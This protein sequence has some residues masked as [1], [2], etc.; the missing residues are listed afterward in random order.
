MTKRS[1][2]TLS[3]RLM[4]FIGIAVIAVTSLST[5]WNYQN[6]REHIREEARLRAADTVNKTLNQLIVM[7]GGVQKSTNFLA[8]VVQNFTGTEKE[9]QN[10]LKNTISTNKNIYGGTIALAIKSTE[11]EKGFAPYYFRPEGKL[12]YVDLADERY[13]YYQQDWFTKAVESMQPAWSEP[14]FDDGGGNIRMITYAVPVYR[15][16]ADNKKTIYAVVTGDVSLH[17][18]HKL[19]QTIQLGDSGYAMLFSKK[20][21]LLSH[22]N[23]SLKM[24]NFLDLVNQQDN[25]QQWMAI[26]KAMFSGKRDKRDLPCLENK[27]QHCFFA[28]GSLDI[29][30][31][32]LAVSFPEKEMF[33]ELDQYTTRFSIVSA[34]V[35]LFLLIIIGMITSR[36]TQP[37]SSLSKASY[38]IGQGDFDV[39]LPYAKQQDEVGKLVSAFKKMQAALKDYIDQLEV[40]TARTSRLEGELSAAHQ[41]QMSMLPGNGEIY[42]NHPNHQLWAKLIPAKSVG[43]DLYQFSIE[44]NNKLI[45]VVAD[46]SDKGVAAALFMARTTSL[47]KQQLHA[48][49]SA[50]QL[51]FSMNNELIEGNDACMFVTL[52]YAEL[53]LATG[54]MVYVSA[55]H[56]SPLLIRGENVIALP[57][58]GGPALGLLDDGEYPLNHAQLEAD[59]KLFIYTDGVDEAFN[60]QHEQFGLT[61]LTALLQQQKNEAIDVIGKQCFTG[62]DNFA[63]NTE[64]SDDI[65]VM[66]VHFNPSF[67]FLMDHKN[68]QHTQSYALS[69]DVKQ[70]DTVFSHL[71]EFAS[72]HQLS[73]ACLQN[74]KLIGEEI[75]V[76]AISYSGMQTIQTLYFVL[77]LDQQGLLMEFIDPGKAY[78]PLTDAPA[79]P[80]E[81]DEIQ[82]GGLG[83]HFVKSLSLE[84]KYQ[85][86][87]QCNHLCVLLPLN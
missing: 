26:K 80:D 23:K 81:D 58:E 40:E 71:N 35:I 52:F 27:N 65:T 20:G 43:G 3:Q 54:A 60:T 8:S 86:K 62:I 21:L 67:N 48:K 11:N 57:Q 6:S 83:I 34:A 46:V 22:P 47:F 2:L 15:L 5:A 64:Q 32:P 38:L 1:S 63:I 31:W 77:G 28:Y 13:H 72:K 33:A 55:G 50:D 69:C 42:E 85:Y 76:N 10:L 74:M 78:N 51:L 53:N 7:V 84:Q 45:F 36:L 70:L 29:T 49:L 14:Y 66:L 30:G 16:N 19:V 61:R 18:I 59:D 75:L 41:I 25:K 17:R 79:P 44:D 68:I 4:I 24:T 12:Q 73:D 37:L 9:L 39:A 56:H 87:G 82:I